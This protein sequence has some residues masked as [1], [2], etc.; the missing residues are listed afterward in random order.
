MPK[1]R[2][3]RSDDSP[4]I[5]LAGIDAA[6]GAIVGSGWADPPQE[7]QARLDAGL[8]PL[9][10][11]TQRRVAAPEGPVVVMEPQTHGGALARVQEVTLPAQRVRDDSQEPEPP[12]KA[13]LDIGLLSD[14]V[15]GQRSA[16]D[17]A[18]A[19]GVTL[20]ELHS[21]LATTLSQVD[22][23]ELAKAMGVQVTVTQLK[24][25]AVFNAVLADLLEDIRSGRAKADTKLELLKILK[26][27]GRLEPKEDKGMA[28]GTG[29][30]LNIN[31]GAGAQPVT[32]NAS[33]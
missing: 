16:Q 9:E 33:E 29:F 26:G 11:A 5:D 22:P 32:I 20:N 15:S 4:Q 8:E 21:T 3:P 30:S 14:Y 24:A 7:P 6:L 23:R 17:T 28:P 13:I 25:G 2:S 18:E 31:I 1:T 19:A 27:V 12:N 10:P